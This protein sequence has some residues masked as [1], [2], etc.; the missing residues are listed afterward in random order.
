[1]IQAE[2]DNMISMDIEWH[3]EGFVLP[4][5]YRFQSFTYKSRTVLTQW[6][7]LLEKIL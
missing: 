1:M 5:L 4:N 7:Y 2:L 6:N 3:R